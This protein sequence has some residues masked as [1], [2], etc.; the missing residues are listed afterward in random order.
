MQQKSIIY[1]NQIDNWDEDLNINFEKIW[2][3]ICNRRLKINIIL[4]CIFGGIASF[5]ALIYTELKYEKLTLSSWTNNIIFD[6]MNN[7]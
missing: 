3:T 6:G 1:Y 4:G 7:C 2:K 5:F